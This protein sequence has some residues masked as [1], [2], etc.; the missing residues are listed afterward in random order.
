MKHLHA[1]HAMQVA[2]GLVFASAGAWSQTNP[3][4]GSI[5][6]NSRSANPGVL[7]SARFGAALS[8]VASIEIKADRDGV[9]A[10]GRDAITLTIRVLDR[11]GALVVGDVP[12][13]L[14]TNRGRFVDIEATDSLSAAI[15]RERA[16]S[17]NQLLARNGV[18]VV[19]LQA[20]G[21]PG[22]AQLKVSAG[23]RQSTAT[24]TFVPDL[25]ELIA[26]GIIDGIVNFRSGSG[27]VIQ[28]T[29][30]SDGFEREL[31]TLSREFN[32]G[33]GA[34]GARTA[35]F[36]KGRISGETLLTASYDSDK[37]VRERLFRDIRPEEFYPV[38]GDASLTGFDAQSSSRLY[39]RLDNGKSFLLWGDF[40]TGD[41]VATYSNGGET[42][43]LGRYSRALTGVQGRW[44]TGGEKNDQYQLQAFA[45]KDSLRQVVDELPGRGISGPYTLRY[46][47]G[48]AGSERIELI[49]RD[50]NA[51]SVVLQVTPLV[52]FVDYDFEPI[53]GRLLF[54]SPVPSL[55]ANLNPISIRATYEVEGGGE[56]YWVYGGEARA[57]IGEAMTVGATYAKD[58][59]PVAK[60]QL[61]SANAKLQLG[62]HTTAVL[63]VAHSRSGDVSDYGFSTAPGTPA[64]TLTAGASSG[65]AWR[66]ELRHDGAE[67]QARLY[68][69]KTEA[70]FSNAAA[71]L[72]LGVNNARTEAGGKVSYA[73]R[74]GVRLTGE[75]LYSRDDVTG[76]SRGGVFGGVAI[77]LR[78]DLVLEIGLRH[79]E[80][81][82]AG[83]TIPATGAAGSVPG[84]SVNPVNGG[85]L[86][87]P[88]N[89]AAGANDPYNTT[90][91]KGK[92]TYRV[93]DRASVFVEGEQALN[94]NAA[95]D[96]GY[97][98]ALGGEYR[99]SDVGRLYARVERASGLG[100]DYGLSGEGR[101]TAT[102]VGIDTQ[103]MRD[104]Q[105]FSE[106]R[107]RDAIGGPE[108]VAA[109]GLRN[110]W[111]VSEGLRLNTAVERV[112]VLEGSAQDG[113]AVALGLDY[114]GSEIWKGST[115]LEWRR[116]GDKL[117]ATAT[118]SWLHSVAVARKI[119]D[120]WTLLARNLYLRKITPDGLADTTENRFQIGAAWR[121]TA[122][123]VWSA[124]GRYEYR[125]QRDAAVGDDTRKHIVSVDAT[126]HPARP[127]WVTGKVA[128]K[129]VNARIACITDPAT[130]VTSDCVDDTTDAQLV[131]A[132]VTYDITPRWDLGLIVSALGESGFKNR[133][134]GVGAEV[135]Y[136]VMENLWLSAGYNFRGV[137]DRDL[138]TD[139]SARGVYLRLRFKFDEKLFSRGQA[140]LDKS[141][142]PGKP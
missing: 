93:N 130:G 100:G 126:Y 32:A 76:G 125:L 61:A 37:D 51:P 86:I 55:D 106:Y 136:L 26:V 64:A 56:K 6:D 88:T 45:S 1:L 15:D 13:T 99:F 123:N 138:L 102:V 30:A 120:D 54:K 35:F 3:G 5:N 129:W 31:R 62:E 96:K 139:Y 10:N 4:Y 84:T 109:V 63:E 95:G 18:L 72:G 52:R 94:D 68:G 46:P 24:L 110:V 105:L 97:G 42:V 60:Y 9:P 41:S 113:E 119:D 38:Y 115:R 71:T 39:V 137:V 127:W 36:L 27:T 33:R 74:E 70:G 89:T 23:P 57:R 78:S 67:L 124:L 25:R 50:R 58:E 85:S 44:Q 43:V 91:V 135:G 82:G 53:S 117:P 107:L 134:Y 81:R 47:N 21:E 142:V 101:Q 65:N 128:G 118:T 111:R 40:T 90:S 79:S 140:G 69:Q 87:D 17:G 34:Y 92:L 2:L 121:E 49:V 66:A 48:V 22:D 104:G 98:Y 59:N 131:Q 114:I 16:V 14:E 133:N 29:R 132:R 116:D 77:D 8:Q 80:Q 75:A 83:A 122:T 12:L 73:L 108:S 19:K 141:V 103:Y 20:P 28:P 7:D 11:A 112:R